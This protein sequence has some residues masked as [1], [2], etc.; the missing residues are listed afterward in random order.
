MILARYPNIDQN[1]RWQWL[2]AGKVI[3]KQKSFDFS[4]NRYYDNCNYRKT[5]CDSLLMQ[6]EYLRSSSANQYYTTTSYAIA[7][8]YLLLIL[9]FGYER[10][11]CYI[12]I[13]NFISS[14]L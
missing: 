3:D 7:L 13:Y 1:G 11:S 14:V 4:T 5:L 8:F 6:Q 2:S 10:S 9:L 12:I